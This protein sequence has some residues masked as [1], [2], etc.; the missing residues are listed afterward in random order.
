M[1]ISGM[2]KVFAGSNYNEKNEIDSLAVLKGE[3]ISYQILYTRLDNGENQELKVSADCDSWIG[4]Q[5]IDVKLVPANIDA[6]A[7][8]IR[9]N[10]TNSEITETKTM[11]LS[12]INCVFPEQKLIYTQ[13]FHA[14]CIADYYD[15]DVFS[16]EHWSM[17]DKFVKTQ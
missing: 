1:Q 12:V 16:G 17:I 2:E 5:L 11:K 8:E 4:I 10:F 6:G 15:I 9:L 14:D 3:R 13:W 7:Y